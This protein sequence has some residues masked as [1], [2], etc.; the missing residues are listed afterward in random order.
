MC[1]FVCV[2][3]REGKLVCLRDTHTINTHLGQS[4]TT[5]KK[6]VSMSCR[7]NLSTHT[8]IVIENSFHRL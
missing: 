2:R 4:V 3:E 5:G 8:H 6:T 7:R 1:M